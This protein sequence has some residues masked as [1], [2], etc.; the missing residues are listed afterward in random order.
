[1]KVCMKIFIE[2][3]IEVAKIVGP[4]MLVALLVGIASNYLQIGFLF[5]TETIQFKLEK[6][7]PIKGFKRIFSLRSVI[8]F[9][10]SILKIFI[11]SHYYIFCYLESNWMKFLVFITKINWA[12]LD[13]I[14]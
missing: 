12:A 10:K 14:N 11:V 13:D 3:L 8:E 9:L 4:I 1:M 7:D 5:T 6:I 2:V